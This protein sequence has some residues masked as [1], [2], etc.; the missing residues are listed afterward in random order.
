MNH[1]SLEALCAFVET[2]SVAKAGERM[3][4]SSPQISRLLADLEVEVGFPV[5]SRHGRALALT[6]R[7]HKLYSAV[8]RFLSAKNELSS[9]AKRLQQDQTDYLRIIS[10]PFIGNAFLNEAVA[11]VVGENKH[12]SVEIDSYTR[13]DIEANLAQS[14][15]DFAIISL[16]LIS[17]GYEIIPFLQVQPVVAMSPQHPLAALEVV[18]FKDLNQYELITTHPHSRL[19]RHLT[20]LASATGK[21]IKSRIEAKNGNIAC[22]LAGEPVGCCLADPFMALFCGAKDLVLRPFDTE[23]RLEYGFVLP[24]WQT[25]TRIIDS[26]ALNIQQATQKPIEKYNLNACLLGV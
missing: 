7:G 16:P 9:F 25:R 10:A 17:G 23:M 21:P 11:K 5:F 4:R 19:H 24:E 2:G 18:T 20:A 6:D 15:F 13:I 8:V 12:L 22:Q 3:L 1:R 26:L 14:R